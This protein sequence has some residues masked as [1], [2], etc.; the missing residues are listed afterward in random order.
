M[1]QIHYPPVVSKSNTK[2]A[3]FVFRCALPEWRRVVAPVG[4]TCCQPT[5]T[6]MPVVHRP[7]STEVNSVGSQNRASEQKTTSSHSFVA[8]RREPSGDGL[9]HCVGIHRMFALI[10]GEE[11]RHQS[12][13]IS[14]PTVEEAVT[15]P[16]ST[17]LQDEEEDDSRDHCQE[18]HAGEAD[19]DSD[20]N[21]R[22][23]FGRHIQLLT[24]HW[25]L[26]PQYGRFPC[27]GPH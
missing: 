12:A 24:I 6:P 2:T 17:S 26:A 9:C 19:A 27:C 5:R 21:P 20:P 18:K 11:S 14:R 13:R 22:Q 4:S 1:Y 15:A 7:A 25:C 10:R 8:A 3:E 16:T 23:R